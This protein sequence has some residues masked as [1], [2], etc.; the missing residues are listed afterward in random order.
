MYVD[1][2]YKINLTMIR[3][4]MHYGRLGEFEKLTLTQ[5]YIMFHSRG[6]YSANMIPKLLISN[7]PQIICCIM[8]NS[9]HSKMTF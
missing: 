9:L 3:L 1:I 7:K 8:P 5:Q 6:Q 2:N 4:D